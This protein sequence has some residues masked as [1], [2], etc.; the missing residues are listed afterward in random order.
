MKVYC[1]AKTNKVYFV[2]T[3]K[4]RRFYL[5]TGLQTTEKMTGMV[6]P[7]S[8]KSAKSKTNRL[9]HLFAELEDYILT[10]N[11]ESVDVMKTHLKDIIAGGRKYK[12]TFLDYLQEL[13]EKKTNKATVRLYMLTH[14]RIS[15]FDSKCTFDTIDKKWLYNFTEHE[16]ARGRK[17]NGIALDMNHIKVVFNWAINNDITDKYPFIRFKVRTEKTRNRNLTITE[18]RSLRDAQ[19]TKTQRQFLDVFMLGF[20]LI[21]INISDLLGLKKTDLVDGRIKYHRN[22]T[23]RLYDIKVEP[24]AMEIFNRYAGDKYLLKFME[25]KKYKDADSFRGCMNSSLRKIG[26]F[27]EVKGNSNRKRKIYHPLFPDISTY[28][29]RHTWATLASDLNIPKDVIGR[30]LGHSYWDY[31]VTDIYI[32]FDNK[33]IDEANRKVIDYL[34]SDLV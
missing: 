4:T 20:Y 28:W 24:E 15:D 21:G 19:V 26:S 2:V 10:H 33:K 34:N 32:K 7:K 3:Y 23:G 6:F 16:K 25:M 29:N 31:T 22:K 12:K 11:N 14:K 1:E 18:L 9:A 13:A 8:D 27:D 30:A 17:L 5:Y